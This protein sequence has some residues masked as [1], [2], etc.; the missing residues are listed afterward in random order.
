M[1]FIVSHATRSM[2]LPFSDA[3]R[4]GDVLCLSGQ[5]GHR[6]GT[7]ELVPGG[8][9]PQTRQ[10]MENT[11]RILNTAGRSF[12]D[13]FKCM[14]MLADMSEWMEFNKVY[15]EYFKPERLP[16][17]SAFGANGLALGAAVE[18]ECWAWA[19]DAQGT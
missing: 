14:V 15:L 18:M 16:A 13:V 6:P 4:V 9:A 11:A 10:M 2:G 19:G 8:I 3:V 5:I 17:R 12:D 1:D 7:L